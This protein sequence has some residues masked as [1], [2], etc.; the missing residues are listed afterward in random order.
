MRITNIN[1]LI[2]LSS[3]VSFF[4]LGCEGFMSNDLYESELNEIE[5]YEI[6]ETDKPFEK[7][8][9]AK[10]NYDILYDILETRGL[11]VEPVE[12]LLEGNEVSAMVGT[13][14][15]DPSQCRSQSAG[16]V[17]GFGLFCKLKR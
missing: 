6:E 14:V 4:I 1:H 5:S 15:E 3:I 11:L 2:I 9:F 16:N 12:D 17:P 7:L 8:R 13:S 10:T